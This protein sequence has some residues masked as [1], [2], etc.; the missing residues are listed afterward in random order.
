MMEP[1]ALDVRLFV[2]DFD[3]EEEP[4]RLLDSTSGDGEQDLWCSNP[5][6]GMVVEL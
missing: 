5:W 6:S 1:M 4:P 3:G 2:K